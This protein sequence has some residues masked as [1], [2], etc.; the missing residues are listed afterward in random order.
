M[1]VL[2]AA[3]LR[4][5]GVTAATELAEPAL[6]VTGDRVQLQQVVLNLIMNGAEAPAC[7]AR[8][9]IRSSG[10][11]VIKI[12]GMRSERPIQRRQQVAAC[13]CLAVPSGTQKRR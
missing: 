6:A 1:L 4:A 7:S 10:K 11:A 13:S 9:R 12:T 5:R 2:V 3:E 8:V